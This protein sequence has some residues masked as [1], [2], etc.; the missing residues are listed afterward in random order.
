MNQTVKVIVIL[1][2]AGIAGYFVVKALAP[3][4]T[5]KPR[6]GATQQQTTTFLSGLLGGVLPFFNSGVPGGYQPP[7]TLPV[8]FDPTATSAD[9]FTQPG[10]GLTTGDTA[11][12]TT[13]SLSDTNIFD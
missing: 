1:G 10:S 11:S 5:I 8:G 12:F 4:P 7:P 3:G 2:V 9:N 13:D 6:T